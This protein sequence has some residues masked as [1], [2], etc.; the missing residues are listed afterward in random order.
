MRFNTNLFFVLTA[1]FA[2]ICLVPPI[3]IGIRTF[4]GLAVDHPYEVAGNWDATLRR[5]S[6]LGLHIQVLNR[7]FRIGPNTINISIKTG[8]NLP[9]LA[10]HLDCSVSRPSTRQEDHQCVARSLGEGLFQMTVDFPSHGL[11]V[12]NLDIPDGS[13]SLSF[14][15]K[16]WVNKPAPDQNPP[17]KT[18]KTVGSLTIDFDLSP[19]PLK[20]MNDLTF[21][22]RLNKADEPVSTATVT[23]D[24]TMPGMYMGKNQITLSPQ[25]PGKYVG[26]GVVTICPMHGKIWQA[27]VSAQGQDFVATAAFRF[28]VE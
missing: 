16:I 10:D 4:D 3:I 15:E 5:K 23:I 18:Q 28:E 21:S 13:G 22:V 14:P 1:I 27:D 9:F 26:T 25:G 6:A 24:L 19:K 20:A 11:W 2:V 8:Q 7:A 17:E 12:L